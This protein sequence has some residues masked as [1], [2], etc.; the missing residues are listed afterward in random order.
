[1]LKFINGREFAIP[2]ELNP[3]FL[4]MFELDA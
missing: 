2:G 1:M 4:K 3:Q